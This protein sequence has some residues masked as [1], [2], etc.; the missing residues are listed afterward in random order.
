MSAGPLP[1]PDTT[2]PSRCHTAWA[3]REGRLVTGLT[4]E[5]GGLAV[6]IARPWSSFLAVWMCVVSTAC[7]PSVTPP[8]PPPSPSPTALRLSLSQPRWD[9]GTRTLRVAVINDGATP[10]SV[11]S[12]TIQSAGFQPEVA[13]VDD[14]VT[15]PG[16]I[17]G[18]AVQHGD[19]ICGD[20]E[21]APVS[22]SV[23]VDDSERVLPLEPDDEALL[24]R[25]HEQDC[26]QQRLDAA[27]TL[28]LDFD[29]QT[30]VRNGEEY[31]LGALVVQRPPDADSVEP[32]TVVSFRGSVLLSLGPD[33]RRLHKR[34]PVTLRPSAE[35]LRVPVLTG[36][37]HRCDPHALTN[38]SQTF[39]FNS[40]VRIGDD[41]VQRVLT[42]PSA[43]AKR[44]LGAII[45]RDCPG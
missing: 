37:E 7:S 41:P 18:F 6:N 43:A 42:I 29:E 11:S 24:G 1:Q 20:A 25:L 26:R 27:A 15:E 35:Q 44:Q 33:A 4:G 5:L 22:L 19:A 9:E 13:A 3:R 39:L 45:D 17:A 2:S 40:F 12:A 23:T 8:P 10:I 32:V 34:L 30:V 38:S 21:V 31:L 36:S 28:R 16:G 14:G